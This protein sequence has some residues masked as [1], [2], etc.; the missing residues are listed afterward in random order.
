MRVEHGT[1]V[2]VERESAEL[3][4]ICDDITRHERLVLADLAFHLEPLA[5]SDPVALHH[6]V[7]KAIFCF[8]FFSVCVSVLQTACGQQ[9][10]KVPKYLSPSASTGDSRKA[11]EVLSHQITHWI[12]RTPFPFLCTA[13]QLGLCIA[14]KSLELLLPQVAI[15]D[16][17]L[18]FAFVVDYCCY[19][20][21]AVHTAAGLCRV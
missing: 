10:F 18:L 11:C 12:L 2:K 13:A 16:F 20:S 9:L 17:P 4:K 14:H 8:F 5:P 1:V 15:H 21:V 7:C 6:F 3:A 19:S